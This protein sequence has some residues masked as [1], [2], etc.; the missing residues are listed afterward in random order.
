MI[1][2]MLR[3]LLLLQLATVIALRFLDIQPSGGAGAGTWALAWAS[4][5]AIVMLLRASITAQ[6]FGLS[7]H[8]RSATPQQHRP[9]LWGRCR[10]FLDE[11]AATM[12]ASCW[13]MAWPKAISH[14][15]PG[16]TGLPVLLVHGYACNSGYW[17]QLSA[18]L[19]QQRISH[20]AIDLEPLGAAIDDYVPQLQRAILA[21]CARTGSSEVIIVAHSMGGLVARACLRAC[22]N[23]RIARVITLGTPHHGTHLARFGIGRNARQMR[24]QG[25]RSDQ[26]SGG[27]WLASLAA[28]ESAAQRALFSSIFSHHD[29]IVAPQTSARLPGAK[30]IEFGGVG[31]VAMGRDRRILQCVLDE[32]RLARRTGAAAGATTTCGAAHEVG[33]GSHWN[34]VSIFK[35]AAKPAAQ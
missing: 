1:A 11:F 35:R 13:T 17:T 19:E 31:H 2:R 15:V 7:W 24:R 34:R 29:N 18:L 22:G 25:Q 10:L 8:Y 5:L 16:A 14:I 28:G 23:T 3:W 27:G 33:G 12:L 9:R 20:H 6:N 4:S 32:I 26:E 30:N 21:L